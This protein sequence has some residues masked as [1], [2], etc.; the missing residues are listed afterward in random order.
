MGGSN[1]DGIKAKKS[2]KITKGVSVD[3]E[4]EEAEGQSSGMLQR[5]GLEREKGRD[6]ERRR[7]RSSQR[8]RAH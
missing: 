7:I 6:G 8:G 3:R 2:V 1:R 5:W 4:L